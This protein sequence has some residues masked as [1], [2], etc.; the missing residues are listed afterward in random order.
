MP[1]RE[2]SGT[3]SLPTLP[4][5]FYEI[6]AERLAPRL[7]GKTLLRVLADGTRL[8][9]V[10]V[11]AE[12]YLGTQDRASHAFGGRRTARNEVMYGRSGLAYVYFT[13][14]MHFMFNVACLR[15]GHP[16]AV[17]VRALAPLEGVE[18][19]REHRRNGQARLD[20]RDLCSGPG[21][22]CQA[23]AIDRS[24]NGTDLVESDQLSIIGDP[25]TRV[26]RG[27]LVR[28]TRIGVESAGSWAS[29]ELRWYLAGSPH[30]SVLAPRV[31]TILKSSR[32]RRAAD[33][34]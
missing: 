34:V 17:L 30:V 12:A 8:S 31:R 19:M 20:D 9:G 3:D 27:R 11:E 26:P 18:R 29:R 5:S 28:S 6:P 4:R 25:A 2:D 23:L 1:T 21:K 32:A 16:A 15:E 10:I 7:I 24:L 13:Y 22:L 33:A 14:G